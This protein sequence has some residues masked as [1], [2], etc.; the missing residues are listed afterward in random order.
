MYL[1]QKTKGSDSI[2]QAL[3]AQLNHTITLRAQVQ[4]AQ[5]RLRIDDT[6][7]ADLLQSLSN[8]LSTIG[9]LINL[10]LTDCGRIQTAGTLAELPARSEDET[11]PALLREFCNY[12]RNT[13]DRKLIADQSNDFETAILL[14]RILTF[15]NRSLWFLDVYSNA[16]SIKCQLSRLPKWNSVAAGKQIA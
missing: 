3:T 16:M 13:S 15:T 12:D 8:E 4:R 5:M 6:S 1:K 11:F 2:L 7:A 14:D 10:R 9:K